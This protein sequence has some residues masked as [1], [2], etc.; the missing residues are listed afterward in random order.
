MVS[1]LKI[2]RNLP[3]KGGGGGKMIFQYLIKILNFD[4]KKSAEE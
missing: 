1:F 4:I 3:F 2:Q